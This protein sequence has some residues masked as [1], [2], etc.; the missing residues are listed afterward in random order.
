MLFKKKK[1]KKDKS[2]EY[3]KE[4]KLNILEVKS[5]LD[6]NI[7][8]KKVHHKF[9]KLVKRSFSKIFKI[10]YQFTYEEMAADIQKKRISPET[11]EIIKH[12]CNNLSEL[13]YS[14]KKITLENLYSMIS[15]FETAIEIKDIK[16]EKAKPNIKILGSLIKKKDKENMNSL[17][18]DEIKA[19][20]NN[21]RNLFAK[22][23]KKK[24]HEKEGGKMVPDPL[25]EIYYDQ[26]KKSP[27]QK[28][29]KNGFLS[30]DLPPPP[31]FPSEET[32]PILPEIPLKED[33][34]NDEKE[35]E[36]IGTPNKQES[37]DEKKEKKGIFGLFTK[38]KETEAEDTVLPAF[39]VNEEDIKKYPIKED[40]FEESNLSK[41]KLQSNIDV[42]LK[43][44]STDKVELN[45]EFSEMKREKEKL[46]EHK[47]KIEKL[48][49]SLVSGNEKKTSKKNKS[50]N[51]TS[52]QRKKLTNLEKST[53]KD[54]H[55][56]KSK[57]EEVKKLKNEVSSLHSNV[58][59][60]EISLKKKEKSLI[61]KETQ[62]NEINKE[63]S[64]NESMI[65][66]KEKSLLEKEKKI[67][68]IK[69]ELD[70][71]SK[72]AKNEINSF[73]KDLEDKKNKFL[74]IQKYFN[75]RENRLSVE[76]K[77]FLESK[78]KHVRFLDN[79]ILKYK[80]LLTKEMENNEKTLSDL[81]QQQKNNENEFREL[82]IAYKALIEEK[83]NLEEASTNKKKQFDTMEKEFSD[84][85][86]TLAKYAKE[87][88]NRENIVLKKELELKRIESDLTNLG[89]MMK[90][91]QHEAEMRDLDIKD[92]TNKIENNKLHQEIV[93]KKIREA[94]AGLSGKY[95][96]FQDLQNNVESRIRKKRHELKKA[97]EIIKKTE[98]KLEHKKKNVDK[99]Y[100]GLNYVG[101]E[102][103]GS[104]Y[105]LKNDEELH[106]KEISVTKLNK[107][108]DDLTLEMGTPGLLDI[109]RMLN[110]AKIALHHGRIDEAKNLYININ[111][112][113]SNLPPEEQDEIYY[114]ILK[115]YKPEE[116]VKD[117]PKPKPADY[118]NQKLEKLNS[119][120][121]KKSD[122]MAS[123]IAGFKSCVSKN[124]MNN[125]NLIYNQIQFSYR[126]LPQSEKDKHYNDI[127]SLYRK[128]TA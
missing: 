23:L 102:I 34:P 15:L 57:I 27:K 22:I 43:K 109:Y 74:M 110:I 2:K 87:I 46:Q 75:Q 42:L 103:Y 96:E 6:E 62:L 26:A 65:K 58:K 70:E 91:M 14:N 16:P 24:E 78:R 117:L 124:D 106:I 83:K 113:Y 79:K 33:I 127:I 71:H 25:D 21:D 32:E 18:A 90:K 98:K 17:D 31:K 10:H 11:K 9:A 112:T 115:I 63:L 50:S 82:H 69:K 56:L 92:L 54:E 72:K 38:K 105:Y 128:I 88:M 95:K 48:E 59:K 66:E 20:K 125:A 114:D 122:D 30:L 118:V 40:S 126:M 47:I 12:I 123:L 52:S 73:K 68:G 7:E 107:K 120:V 86:P 49:K 41:D 13:E 51:K 111:E 80:E 44:I 45:Q 36:R 104:E 37:N 28:T 84:K 116:G 29:K 85:G 101:G 93:I 61:D 77:T 35:N 97:E 39:D 121:E 119:Q 100:E 5:L 76:E 19:K 81:K 3:R 60:N 94:K 64:L 1:V 53:E 55:G 8:L 99:F 4:A 89:T 67:D 108:D